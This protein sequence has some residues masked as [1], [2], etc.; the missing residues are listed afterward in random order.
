MRPLEEGFN[1]ERRIMKRFR[2]KTRLGILLAFCWFCV[3]Y[4]LYLEN[5]P[6]PWGVV[7]L[8]GVL[9]PVLIWGIVWVAA[10]FKR[11]GGA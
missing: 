9:P 11:G 1:A 2:G 5:H 10:G 8:V 3:V 7:F 4:I 6:Y